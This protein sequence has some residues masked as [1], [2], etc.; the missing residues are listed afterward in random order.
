[1]L[2][3]LQR[4]DPQNT[5]VRRLLREVQDKLS[6]QQKSESLRQIVLQA[7]QAFSEHKYDAALESYKQAQKLDPTNHG[8][9]SKVNQIRELKERADRVEALKNEAREARHRQDFQAAGP[10]SPG[11]GAACQRGQPPQAEGSR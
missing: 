10:D 5:E 4:L 6:R 7:E 1:M 3:D 2:L 8:F 9:T 11:A